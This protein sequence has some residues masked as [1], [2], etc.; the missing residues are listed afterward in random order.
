MQV[1]ALAAKT[2]RIAP[3]GSQTLQTAGILKGVLLQALT[4]NTPLTIDLDD[5][6]SFDAAALQLL[7]ATQKTAAAAGHAVTVTCSADS[8]AGRLISSLGFAG[9][10]GWVSHERGAA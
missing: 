2:S 10:D 9:A 5:A 1:N 3:E 8:A 6:E 7:V 4:A